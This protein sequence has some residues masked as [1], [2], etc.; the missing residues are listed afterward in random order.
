MFPTN[1]FFK[2]R[3]KFVN[4][5]Y[6][7]A[8]VLRDLMHNIQQAQVAELFKFDCITLPLHIHWSRKVDHS[9]GPNNY[10]E[11]L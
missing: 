10:K 4:L 2:S 8:S 6:L 9:G 7:E 5:P 11:K 1:H 3:P